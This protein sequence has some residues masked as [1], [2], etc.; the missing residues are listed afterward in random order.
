MT[1]KP[2]MPPRGNPQSQTCRHC[3]GLRLKLRGFWF[4]ERCDAPTVD[5]VIFRPTWKQ[6]PTT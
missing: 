2:P 6:R 4:C 1:D 5:G 3:K